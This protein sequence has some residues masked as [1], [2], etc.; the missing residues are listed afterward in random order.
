[1]A[2]QQRQ[3][4]THGAACHQCRQ[5]PAQ[6]RLPIV[7]PQQ[8]HRVEHQRQVGE[9]QQAVQPGKIPVRHAFEQSQHHQRGSEIERPLAYRLGAVSPLLEQLLQGFHRLAV[10]GGWAPRA[11]ARKQTERAQ[12]FRRLRRRPV[13]QRQ[14]QAGN[15]Q[16]LVQPVH[17]V[18]AAKPALQPG[19]PHGQQHRHTHHRHAE[20]AAV[21]AEGIAPWDEGC[22]QCQGI[23]VGRQPQGGGQQQACPIQSADCLHDVLLPGCD[24]CSLS[25]RYLSRKITTHPLTSCPRH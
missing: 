9:R 2:P 24:T 18:Q 22:W 13:Q 16:P 11:A 17:F 8:H 25:A 1:M 20:H 19:W 6:R 14:Y 23:R 4:C 7:K 3:H 21:L 15:A 10:G 5:Q 12:P